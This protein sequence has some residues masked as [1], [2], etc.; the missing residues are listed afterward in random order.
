MSAT[1]RRSRTATSATTRCGASLETRRDELN[2]WLH[3]RSRWR[4]QARPTSRRRGRT[5]RARTARSRTRRGATR[6]RSAGRTSRTT[7]WRTTSLRRRMP[8]AR[9][10]RTSAS[11]GR[12]SGRTPRRSRSSPS[13]AA[14]VVDRLAAAIHD[15]AEAPAAACA[16]VVHERARRRWFNESWK[17]FASW[18][19]PTFTFASAPVSTTAGTVSG[20]LTVSL[21][22]AGVVRADVNPRD[23]HAASSSAGAVFATSPDGPWSSTLA[24]E[25]RPARPTRPSTTETPSPARRRSA[26]PRRVVPRRNR[27]RPCRPARSRRSGSR[28]RRRPSGARRPTRSARP[29][30]TRSATRS[31]S[32]PHWTATLGKVSPLDGATT[33]Y[34]PDKAGTATITATSGAVAA[35]VRVTVK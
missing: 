35:S 23:G 25:S 31:R 16:G 28:G 4:T 32:R 2:A 30:Q 10:A 19:T 18:S 15:S 20:P 6:R 1:G 27:S 33:T 8:R 12:R 22:L 26:S 9:P 21:Q 11:P 24:V 3:I 14:R 13:R 34:K 7:R 29:A 5:S 17:D